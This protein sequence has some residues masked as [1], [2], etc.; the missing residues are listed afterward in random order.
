MGFRKGGDRV[1]AGAGVPAA[2][3]AIAA[4]LG[5]KLSDVEG[6]RAGQHRVGRAAALKRDDAW[7]G[8][9][10]EVAREMLRR[11]AAVRRSSGRRRATWPSGEKPA[12][13]WE[14]AGQRPGWHMAGS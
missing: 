7:S 11:R 1:Q 3:M 6:A 2:C 13:G 14:A 12:R 8:G 5:Q 10:Q 9:R 4:A